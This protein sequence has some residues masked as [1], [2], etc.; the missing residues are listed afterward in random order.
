MLRCC[1]AGCLA[2]A[3]VCPG[4]LYGG[5]EEEGQLHGLWRA[6]W[7]GAA[8]LQLLGDGT[9]RCAC[10]CVAGCVQQSKYHVVVELP[11]PEKLHCATSLACVPLQL[12]VI[13]FVS[14]RHG[15][16]APGMLCILLLQHTAT[17]V[18]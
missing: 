4:L 14:A 2:T 6:A 13:R 11:G 18:C 9:N 7:Q 15:M 16:S 17:L 5:G 3:V 12:A 8:P 1:R 10:V